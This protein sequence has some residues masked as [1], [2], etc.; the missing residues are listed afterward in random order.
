[1]FGQF[2]CTLLENQIWRE[3]KYVQPR[4]PSREPASP[5]AI[6][7]F[8]LGCVAFHCVIKTSPPPRV[9]C[10]EERKVGRERE[11]QTDVGCLL[12]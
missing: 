1:M 4:T 2:N 9:K 5:G 3:S 7:I 8:G 6:L 12:V 10:E 11:R